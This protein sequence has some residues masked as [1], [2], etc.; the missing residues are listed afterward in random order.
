MAAFRRMAYR[1]PGIGALGSPKSMN[2][3]PWKKM[4]AGYQLSVGWIVASPSW[5]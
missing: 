4:L 1:A 3:I 2:F 5:S